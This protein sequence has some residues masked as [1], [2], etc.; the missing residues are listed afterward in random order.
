MSRIPATRLE[1]LNAHIF[2]RHSGLLQYRK[3]VC[4]VVIDML[5]VRVSSVV[6]VLTREERFGEFRRVNVSERA[7]KLM[8]SVQ[9]R[10]SAY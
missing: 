6:V 4:Q 2:P 10:D 3:L 7:V 5:E 9:S 8:V 1:K